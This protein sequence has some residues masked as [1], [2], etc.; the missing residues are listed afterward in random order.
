MDIV[1]QKNFEDNMGKKFTKREI[2]IYQ[3]MWIRIQEVY[4]KYLRKRMEG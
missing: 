1:K 4:G 2:H 3:E